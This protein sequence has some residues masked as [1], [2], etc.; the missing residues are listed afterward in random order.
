MIAAAAVVLLTA[1][2][3]SA[4]LPLDLARAVR[5]YDEAQFHNDVAALAALVADDYVLVNSDGTIED[6]SHLLADFNLP[7]FQIDPYVVEQPERRVWQDTALLSGLIHLRWMQDGR[8]QTRTIRRVDVWAERNGRW[9]MVYTQVTKAAVDRN[10]RAAPGR[11]ALDDA[12]WAGPMLAN[13]AATLPRGHALF[14]PYIYDVAAGRAHA[15]GSRTYALY[16]IADG[17]TV[18][19]IPVFG[20]TAIS[21]GSG[22][23]GVGLG[24]FVLFGQRRLSTFRPG[25]WLPATAVMVQ[26]TLP[27]GRYDRLGRASDGFGAGVY[28]TTVGLNA[29]TYFWLPNGRVMRLRV[30]LTD[31]I[32]G[33]ARVDGVSVYGTGSRFHGMAAPGGAFGADVSTEYSVT[34]RAVLAADVTYRYAS[35]T[36]VSGAIGGAPGDAASFRMDTGSSRSIGIAP[37]VEFSWTP[38]LGVLLGAWIIPP[39]HDTGFS[40]TPAIAINI[41]R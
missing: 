20:F 36:R 21:G 2:V 8:R 1:A 41:V 11:V 12:W 15:F 19:L 26:E 32:P 38:N 37:A 31:T 14:E 9:Q 6:K 39:G 4:A 17:L 16:G 29:Q 24:D 18:G 25:R 40:V 34:R 27:T 10:A 22:S 23:S 3:P 7:G 30:N 13:S 33:R 5:G 35:S 28:A